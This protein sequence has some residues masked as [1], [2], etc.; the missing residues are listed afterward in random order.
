MTCCRRPWKRLHR[1]PAEIPLRIWPATSRGYTNGSSINFSTIKT[2]KSRSTMIFSRFSR[3]PSTSLHSK[4][5]C[6]NGSFSNSWKNRSIPKHDE[7]GIGGKKDIRSRKLPGSSGRRRMRYPCG[8]SGPSGRLRRTFFAANEA[9]GEMMRDKLSRREDRALLRALRELAR[10]RFPNPDRKN[11][12]GTP[13]LHAIATKRISMWDPAHEHV[14]RCSP[15]F[16]ELM[17]M[18]RTLERRKIFLWAIGTTAT[19][20]VVL[21]VWLTFFGSHRVGGTVRPQTAE[22]PRPSQPT[23]PVQAGQTGPTV[24]P[25][26]TTPPP[27]P[28]TEIVLLDLRN[29]S[30]SRSVERPDSNRNRPPVDIRRGMLALTVQ[31]PIGSE[32][33]LY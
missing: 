5:G 17:E 8:S 12:P 20:I 24:T 22:T 3:I 13:V 11:C 21:G 1:R 23:P 28:Q 16:K 6:T 4:C 32:A 26:P 31:L 29:A 19:A 10:T 25:A 27:Q 14:A 15:C 9:Q 2:K 33:G 30:V 7:S 18:R